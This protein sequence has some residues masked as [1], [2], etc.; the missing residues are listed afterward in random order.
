MKTAVRER[1]ITFEIKASSKEQFN[2]GIDIDKRPVVIRDRHLATQHPQRQSL[3]EGDSRYR[4]TCSLERLFFN[5]YGK[6][7]SQFAG[8][9]SY[10]PTGIYQ[11]SAL[12]FTHIL[13]T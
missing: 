9:S 5:E 3:Y 8:R 10:E 4:V 6:N 12:A 11:V 7:G 1:R 13:T 2:I